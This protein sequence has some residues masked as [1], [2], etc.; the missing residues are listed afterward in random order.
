MLHS[1]TLG[2]GRSGAYNVR[3]S[4]ARPSEKIQTS[5][6]RPSA[7]NEWGLFG[8]KYPYDSSGSS[9]V[10]PKNSFFVPMTTITGDILGCRPCHPENGR[11]PSSF[12]AK[13]SRLTAMRVAES[14]A[15]G[16]ASGHV[17]GRNERRA[18]PCAS[19]RIPAL[20]P[21]SADSILS[22]SDLRSRSALMT[23]S[24]ASSK[25]EG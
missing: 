1:G 16:L 19:S 8:H 6:R 4:R 13:A 14:S 3:L 5:G 15:M 17:L 25:V 20:P 7:G 23:C 2:L 24:E 12:W 21:S 11:S 10:Q 18:S 22:R 9:I